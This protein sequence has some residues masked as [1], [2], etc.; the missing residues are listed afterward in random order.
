MSTHGFRL[1]EGDVHGSQIPEAG[2][3]PQPLPHHLSTETLLTYFL[4]ML[5]VRAQRIR[6]II[7][8]GSEE[9]RTLEKITDQLD[10]FMEK[11]A[12]PYHGWRECAWNEVYH[13]ERQIA[14]IEP[15]SNL[16]DEIKRRLDEADIEK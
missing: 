8:A 5:K 10:G 13:L 14:L 2:P 12:T 1:I 6:A 15:D 7:N 16:K 11:F 3:S 9:H 4:S